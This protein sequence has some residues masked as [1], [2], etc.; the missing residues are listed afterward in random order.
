M[1]ETHPSGHPLVANEI[2][3]V[4]QEVAEIDTYRR[5]NLLKRWTRRLDWL[6]AI[7]TGAAE[8]LMVLSEPGLLK[9]MPWKPEGPRLLKLYEEISND[10]ELEENLETARLIR[11][12]YERLVIDRE[13]RP[14]L[15]DSALAHLG[16]PTERGIKSTIYVAV[17]PQYI[18]IMS[19]EYRNNKLALSTPALDNFP[20]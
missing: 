17:Y 20:K 19:R 11:D 16:I 14:Y 13:H 4:F 10:P 18:A 15:G 5:I 6:A 2:G 7:D 12:K 1:S 3:P 9:L 8:V